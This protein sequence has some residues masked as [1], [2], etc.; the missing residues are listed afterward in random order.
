MDRIQP[1]EPFVCFIIRDY[2]N[3]E[4]S[5]G[6][7]ENDLENIVTKLNIRLQERC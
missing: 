2:L 5:G 6:I 7:G 1:E 4:E 3:P